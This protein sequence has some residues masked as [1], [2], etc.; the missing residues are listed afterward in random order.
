MACLITPEFSCGQIMFGLIQSKLNYV[1]KENPY[2]LFLTIKKTFIN[3]T[4]EGANPTVDAFK[5]SA[6]EDMYH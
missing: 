4:V 3:D 2:N 5:Q 1:M 6:V